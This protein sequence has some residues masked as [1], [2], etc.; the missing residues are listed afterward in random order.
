MNIHNHLP[1]TVDVRSVHDQDG[2][3]LAALMVKATFRI[4]Q[5]GETS[6]EVAK[7]QVPWALADTLAG[8]EDHQV[9]VY[10]AESPYEKPHPEFIVVGHAHSP[11]GKPVPEV[12]A[13]IRVGRINKSLVARGPRQ[14]QSGW[15]RSRTGPTAQVVA[16]PLT[17]GQSFGGSDPTRPQDHAKAWHEPN[18]VGTG[19]CAA[20][21]DRRADGMLLP[22]LEPVGRS[23]KR[24]C[25]QFPVVALG[26]VA[27]SALHR[28]AWAGTYDQSWQA[29]R[30]PALPLD[31]DARYHQS[32]SPDQ[33]L[34]ALSSGDEVTLTHLSP[35]LGPLGS[36]LRFKLPKLD[37]K[38]SLHP[39]NGGSTTVQLRADTVVFEPDAERFFVIARRLVPLHEGLHEL[40]AV[41]FGSPKDREQ[42]APIVPTFID[43]DEFREL[44][45]RK[46][47]A[48]IPPVGYRDPL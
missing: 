14:W 21:G 7:D 15:L 40:E 20:P 5:P 22:Q 2:Y 26:C 25:K 36:Q 1:F 45:R 37:F 8:P 43:L 35:A 27:R 18:P 32:T 29:T 34:E 30:W 10:E 4:P 44:L 11:T 39:R 48:V 28:A 13:G 23:F 31:F 24:P 47:P 6:C 41:A 46:R 16:V 12:E 3:E 42:L 33:W 19:Y 17:Y 9:T 38:A